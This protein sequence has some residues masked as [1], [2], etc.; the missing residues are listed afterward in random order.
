MVD[1]TRVRESVSG[2]GCLLYVDQSDK[3]ERPL[4]MIATEIIRSL[5]ALR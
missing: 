3:A 5:T 1:Q 4:H 2:G